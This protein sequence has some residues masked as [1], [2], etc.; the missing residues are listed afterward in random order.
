MFAG[1]YAFGAAEFLDVFAYMGFF[2]WRI[3]VRK[4]PGKRISGSDIERIQTE[5]DNL[6]S[7]IK[8]FKSELDS[9]QSTVRKTLFSQNS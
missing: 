2:H 4:T 8:Q 9:Y 3:M 7:E 1:K 5:M 6:G